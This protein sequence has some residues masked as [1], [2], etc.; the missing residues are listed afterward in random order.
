[1]Q[2]YRITSD[3]NEIS[4]IFELFDRDSSNTINYD[5]F[6]RTIV[7][8]MNERRRQLVS[9]V[10]TRFDFNGNGIVNIEDIKGRY[11]ASQHPDVKNGRKTEEDVL[12]DFLDT[13]E[14]HYSLKVSQTF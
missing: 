7:G 8:E 5:E 12:Y 6:I 4:R 10:F 14:Q 13:F 11:N 3:Q 9:L 1:M 2:D